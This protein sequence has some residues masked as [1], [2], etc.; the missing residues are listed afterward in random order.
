MKQATTEN[1]TTYLDMMPVNS[2]QGLLVDNCTEPMLIY[3]AYNSDKK[4]FVIKEGFLLSDFSLPDGI[5][6]F[7]CKG[8]AGHFTVGYW[9]FVEYKEVD[10]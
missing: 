7:E 10:I 3:G 2:N 6:G 4:V 5:K 1:K 8:K 9:D